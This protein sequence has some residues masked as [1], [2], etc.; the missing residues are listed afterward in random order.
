MKLET[1]TQIKDALNASYQK[2]KVLQTEFDNFKHQL[3]Q[4]VGRIDPNESEE[5][6]KNHIISFLE[7]TF[8]KDKK[9]INT[10]GRNRFGNIQRARGESC[11]S[12]K[13]GQGRGND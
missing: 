10:K 4:F 1:F 8:Y 12:R 5:N 6:A 2:E 7:D 3:Q 11:K 13:A 9:E